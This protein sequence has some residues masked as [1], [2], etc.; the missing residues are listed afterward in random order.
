MAL[1]NQADA[2]QICLQDPI[3]KARIS[4]FENAIGHLG[5]E[6]KKETTQVTPAAAK[7]FIYEVGQYRI[8]QPPTPQTQL[9]LCCGN[10][11]AWAQHSNFVRDKLLTNHIYN[12]CLSVHL[13]ERSTHHQPSFI[14]KIIAHFA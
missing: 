12:C 5:L 7:N 11:L 4:E 6:A 1:V 8:L 3:H 14:P 10:L 2:L 9:C 13:W